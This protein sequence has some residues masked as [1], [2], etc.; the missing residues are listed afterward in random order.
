M[1]KSLL[2]SILLYVLMLATMPAW[3]GEVATFNLSKS[4]GTSTPDGFFTHEE[5]SAAGKWNWN[6][7]YNGA[8]YDGIS[9]SQGLKMEGATAINFTT[10]TV[11]TVTIVQSTWSANT[12]KLDDVVLD[13]ESA[14]NGTGCRIYTVTDVPAGDHVIS[15]GVGESGL[16]YIKVEWDTMKTITFIND[17]NWTKVN[18][19]AWGADN[20]PVTDTWPGTELTEKD[21]EGNYIW[22]TMSEPI[23]ILFNNGITQTPD[24]E[25]KDGGVYN[26]SGRIVTLNDYTAA[27]KTD[28]MDE[29]WAYVWNGE[30]RALGDWPGTKM[31]G[32]SGEF[33]IMIHAEE[34]PEFIIFHNNAGEQTPDW[35]FEN[36]K[37]YEYMLNEYKATFTTD[38]GWASVYAYAWIGDGYSAK[39]LAGEW[40]GTALTATDGVY[41]F[42]IKA[43]AAPEKIIFNGGDAGQTPDLIF[44]NE[45]AYK[46]NTTLK[47]LYTL[48]VPGSSI[49][50]GTTVEI[51]D[52]E[53]VVATLTYGVAGDGDFSAPVALP[54]DEYAGFVNYTQGNGANGYHDSGTVYYIKPKY[55]GT[56]TVGV[57]LREGKA[58]YI[59]EDGKALAGFDGFKQ[60]FTS[61]TAFDFAVKAGSTY[62]IYCT[63]S[64]LGFYGFDYKYKNIVSV[65]GTLDVAGERVTDENAA[66][67]LGDGTFSYDAQKKTLHIKKSYEY[68]D[69]YLILNWD[70]DG[71]TLAVDNDVTLTNPSNPNFAMWLWAST[72]ITGPGKLT[73]YGNISMIDGNTLTIDNA[74]MELL[75][76]YSYSIFGNFGGEKLIVRNSNIHAESYTSTIC[77]FTGGITLEGCTLADGCVIS[78]DGASIVNADGS[79]AKE[80]T[81]CKIDED[82]IK[83]VPGTQKDCYFT[84][85]GRKLQGTPSQHGIYINAGR[86]VLMK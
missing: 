31:E 38:A 60:D 81:I 68:N 35:E 5:A 23:G 84:L 70:I 40:P 10:T 52:G 79:D 48:E 6:S 66:D 29:V 77:S 76:C 15:R 75:L 73:L 57:W 62:T 24:F 21:A 4:P 27:F 51:K 61:G 1:K 58:F 71:L 65:V 12:I 9:F 45:R 28:G 85:D 37:E 17:A 53:D 41:A 50:A 86:K 42:S 14:V 33:S 67:I 3:A 64:K 43:F 74:D 22:R 19:Y 26:S 72:T 30:E 18:V 69:T 20:K 83:D 36:G 7:K 55:D 49:P 47:P 56:I 11:S 59:E 16:F 13:V 63:G 32:S 82:A 39:K 2:Y 44:T 46:W 34:A 8:E 80:V 78:A 25:F 54:N